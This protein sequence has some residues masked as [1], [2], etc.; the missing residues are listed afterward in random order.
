MDVYLKFEYLKK[1]FEFG[2]QISPGKFVYC[3]FQLSQISTK[4]KKH[5]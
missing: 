1:Y 2:A 4:S 3:I 5:G